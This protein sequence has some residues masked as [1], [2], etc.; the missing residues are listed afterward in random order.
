MKQKYFKMFKLISAKFHV[1]ASCDNSN[2]PPMHSEDFNALSGISPEYYST[3]LS[4]VKADIINNF[5]SF[6]RHVGF[7]EF[8]CITSSTQSV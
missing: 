3:I 5:H 8:E 2:C 6:L 7:N 4:G 1:L